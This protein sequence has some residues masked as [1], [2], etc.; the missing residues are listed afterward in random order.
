M[1][2]NDIQVAC[3][4]AS[5]NA[6]E[7]GYRFRD[8]MIDVDAE[9]DGEDVRVTIADHGHWR[10]KRDSDRGRGLDL[11]RGL[12]DEVE[13]VAGEDGTTVRMRKR[14]SQPV[15]L[16]SSSPNGRRRKK[17]KPAAARR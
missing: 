11:I 13:V 12:M 5:S 2:S 14:L 6:M 16:P 15:P 9:F 17:P 8:A 10:E 3:H 4:E 1:E 7:H